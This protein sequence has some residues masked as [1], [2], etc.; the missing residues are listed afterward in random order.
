MTSLQQL[1]Y[2][3]SF[4]L[5]QQR[6]INQGFV[7]RQL[8]ITH[9]AYETY[10]RR[11]LRHAR[12]FLK[13]GRILD[14]GAGNGLFLK[15]AQSAGWEPYG[16]EPSPLSCDISK[17]HF[18][19]EIIN[20]TVESACFPDDFFDVAVMWHVI[21]HLAD[22]V[23]TLRIVRKWLR[24]GG[25]LI[26]EVPNG[27]SYGL[28]VCEGDY[29]MINAEHLTLPDPTAL[30][31]ILECAGFRIACMDT[32]GLNLEEHRRRLS[33]AGKARSMQ[34]LTGY[35]EYCESIGTW[36]RGDCVCGYAITKADPPTSYER[37]DVDCAKELAGR[38]LDTIRP[39]AMVEQDFLSLTGG[40]AR[41][42]LQVA[43]YSRT[44][45]CHL[46]IE[47]LRDG[48]EPIRSVTQNCANMKDNEFVSSV[49]EPIADSEG[50]VFTV[51]ISS[52]DATDANHITLRHNPNSHYMFSEI[53]QNGGTL[54]GSLTFRTWAITEKDFSVGRGEGVLVYGIGGSLYGAPLAYSISI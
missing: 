8:E 27:G 53:R 47:I 25:C 32:T 45:S 18:G 39:S 31:A 52:P 5:N 40:L 16:I 7:T 29:Y 37:L 36:P 49:F 38:A 22:P 21:E 23:T 15:V 48:N 41:I 43:T 34:L 13:N 3:E 14:V 20:G 2:E 28:G 30:K 26:F 9:F 54:R 51:R 11:I 50:K 33:E 44:N 12:T 17:R 4:R 24:P 42:D 35:N 6:L 10:E 1:D 19:I 46:K